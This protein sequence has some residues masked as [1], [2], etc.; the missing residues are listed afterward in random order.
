MLPVAPGGT[1]QPP[2]SPNEDS[3]LIDPALERGEHVGQ[4][5]TPRVVE[6]RRELDAGQLLAGR[7]EELADLKRVGHPGRVAEPDLGRP[8]VDQTAGD[9]EHALSGTWPS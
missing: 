8:G 5:L 7:G 3:K 1:G 2:S 6:V 4:P 9:R